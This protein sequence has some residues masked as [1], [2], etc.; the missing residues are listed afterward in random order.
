MRKVVRPESCGVWYS[1]RQVGEDCEY[2]VQS[3][4]L[5]RK[6]VTDFMYRK[7]K[8]LIRGRSNNVCRQEEGP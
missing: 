1:D 2:S 4:G 6:I 5:E 8:V 7:E 3:T